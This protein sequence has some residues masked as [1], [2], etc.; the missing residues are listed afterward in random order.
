MIRRILMVARREFLATVGSK[1]FILGL[2]LFP[3]LIVVVVLIAPK[4][5]SARS[6]QVRGEVAVIDPTGQVLPELRRMIDPEAIAARREENARRALRRLPPG[7]RQVATASTGTPVPV[8]TVI[9]RPA[10]ADAQAEKSW[11]IPRGEDTRHLALIVFHPDSV[12]RAADRSEYGSYDLYVSPRLNDAT[13]SVIHE[14]VRQALV[15]AR[16][17]AKGLDPTEVEASMRVMRPN[18]VIVAAGGDQAARRG[19]NR[20]LPFIMGMLLFIGV[21]LGGQTLMTFTIEEKSSR[22]VEVLLAAVSP[23]ELMWGKLL[24][25][26]SVGLLTMSIYLGIGL[27]GLFQFSLLGLIDPMLVVYLILFYLITYLMFGAL[28][29]AV[30][31]AVNQMADAQSL[32]GPIVLLLLAPYLFAPIIGQAPNSVF[33]VSVSFIPPVNAFAMLARLASDAPPPHWQAWLSLLIGVGAASAAVWFAAKIFRIGLLMHGK[34]PSF[35]T[36]IRWVRMA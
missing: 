22:V 33:S 31:A 3:V 7:A 17:N 28:M 27:L 34:P 8:L 14:S 10:D 1:G 11:L 30:G 9:E 18:A 26:L 21:M 24:G 15:A 36:L 23:V 5:L 4:I 19:F 35:A 6:P 25:Q 29:M 2:L 20:A 12:T 32:M 16:L 13:E